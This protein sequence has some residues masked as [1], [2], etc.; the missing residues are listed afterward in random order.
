MPLPPAFDR[1][2]IPTG[3]RRDGAAMMRIRPSARLITAPAR[4]C[5]SLGRNAP[6][7][8]NRT[9]QRRQQGLD[10]AKF[11]RALMAGPVDRAQQQPQPDFLRHGC[12]GLG[13]NAHASKP[14]ASKPECGE[15]RS[16]SAR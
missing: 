12:K 11:C 9:V 1:A 6:F 10:L 13:V 3:L 8:S 7:S 4:V 14:L 15:R 2:F 16:R 5:F